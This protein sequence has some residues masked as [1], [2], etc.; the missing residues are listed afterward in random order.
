M[1]MKQRRRDFSLRERQLIDGFIEEICLALHL[2]P[3]DEDLHQCGWAAFLSVYR[4]APHLFSSNSLEGWRRAYHIIWDALTQERRQ[5]QAALYRSVSLDLPVSRDVP[6]SRAQ[7]LQAPHGDFQNSVCFYDYLERM[8]Q[9]VNKMA[10][11]L[12]QGCSIEEI[13]GY[14]RWSKP[15]TYYTYNQLRT[16]LLEYLRI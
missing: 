8:G 14:Y 16:G 7:L 6:V 12:I 5:I 15:H 3:N 11:S 4:D 10:L 1:P 9:D 2:L 13:S